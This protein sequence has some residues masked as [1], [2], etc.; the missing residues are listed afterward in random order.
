M[1]WI[2]DVIKYCFGDRNYRCFTS[3]T[4]SLALSVSMYVPHTEIFHLML[5]TKDPLLICI[6]NVLYIYIQVCAA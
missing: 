5:K 3:P 2:S 1:F 4:L 6:L